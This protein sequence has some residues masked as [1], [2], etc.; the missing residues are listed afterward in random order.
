M[1]KTLFDEMIKNVNI[2]DE[3][4]GLAERKIFLFGHCSA[5]LELV[6]HLEAKGLSVTGILDNSDVKQGLKYKGTTVISP[7]Q[8][9]GI[10]GGNQIDDSVVLISSR[11]YS[12][13]VQQLREL[14]YEG[15]IRKVIDYNTY[16]D[17]S[18]SEET[19]LRMKTRERQG[20][21]LLQELSKKHADFFKVF[22]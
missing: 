12:E 6:D 5:T 21:Y 17:Y 14:G 8:I 7:K 11:F 4:I 9:L 16:S 13:M 18:L 22:C 19:M 10:A 20:E 3:E 2:I 15:P 1:E